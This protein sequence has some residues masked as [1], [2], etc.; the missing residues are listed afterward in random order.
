MKKS[1]RFESSQGDVPILPI[2]R[3]LSQD[4]YRMDFPND[5]EAVV[6]KPDGTIYEV[7]V[8]GETSELGCTCIGGQYEDERK[9]KT[10]DEFAASC[11]HK[12]VVLHTH[13]CE[14]CDGIQ[15]L[16]LYTT[17]PPVLEQRDF[18]RCLN[19]GQVTDAN[20]VRDKRSKKM[21]VHNTESDDEE[22]QEF[23]SSDLP[24]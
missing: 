21:R 6:C 19:C 5:G 10:G 8:T 3:K 16:H 9:A 11:K 2:I 17:P 18:F 4:G 22:P 23:D 20:E 13:V 15:V 12:K 7:S 1:R 14:R 24:F